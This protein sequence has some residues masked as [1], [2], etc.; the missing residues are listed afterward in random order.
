MNVWLVRKHPPMPYRSQ[1]GWIEA[2]TIH[3]VHKNHA[4]ARNKVKD[5]MKRTHIY[6]YT[7]KRLTIKEET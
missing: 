5:L 6:L 4:D 1:R 2:F 3:S 7:V